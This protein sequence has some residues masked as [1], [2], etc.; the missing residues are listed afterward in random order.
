MAELKAKKAGVVV[1]PVV[2]GANFEI[3]KAALL[4]VAGKRLQNAATAHL[5]AQGVTQYSI[6][7]NVC[8]NHMSNSGYKY[9]V[10]CLMI[11]TD[12]THTKGRCLPYEAELWFVDYIINRSAYSET[13]VSKDAEQC[14]ED[15][16]TIS[17]GD[18]PA[19]LMVAGLVALRRLWEYTTV[20]SV[21]YAL[22]QQGVSEDLAFILGHLAQVAEDPTDKSVLTWDACKAGHCSLNPARMDFKA[23]QNFMNHKVLHPN[24]LWSASE[25]TN[26]HGYDGMYSEGDGYPGDNIYNYVRAH[27]PY[28]L[29]DGKPPLGASL[30]IFAKAIPVKG[31]AEV[32]GAHFN[33]AIGVMAEWAKTHLMEKINNA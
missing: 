32:K 29:Y 12:Y 10:N 4:K 22:V 7:G 33:K 15:Q 5:D 21:A 17:S 2:L 8:H 25:Y 28:Y 6:G 9:V 23:L 14:L 31:K 13:F 26:Y 3:A 20:V 24:K 16:M 19:N 27:F 18:H 30:N 1:D 11:G